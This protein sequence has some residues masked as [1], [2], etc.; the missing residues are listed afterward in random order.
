MVKDKL[1]A[2]ATDAHQSDKI[3]NMRRIQDQLDRKLVLEH[4]KSRATKAYKHLPE[5][6]C[7]LNYGAQGIRFEF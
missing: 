1:K 3:A 6:I 2:A 5:Q 7:A 4:I